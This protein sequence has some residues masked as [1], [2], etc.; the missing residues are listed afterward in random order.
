MTHRQPNIF[1][2]F[3]DL[4]AAESLRHGGVSPEPYQSL[5]LGL[6]T[7]D[8]P[9]NVEENRRRFFKDLGLEAAEVAG[10][11]QIHKD[12]VK[13]ISEPGQHEGFDALITDRPNV[14]LTITVADCVPILIYDAEKKAVGAA[15]AGWKGTVAEIGKKTLL[16]MQQQFGTRPA[17]CFVFIGTCIDYDSFEVDNDVAMYFDQPFKRWDDDKGKFFVDLKKVN[18][19]FM[20]KSG[21]PIHQISVSPFS[22]VKNNQDYF[23]HR[24]ERGKTGR[25]LGLIGLRK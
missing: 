3:S 22:T 18:R 13:V 8:T 25:G 24:K 21:V 19:Y 9:E 14:F 4:I 2:S 10:A 7:D 15:H 12:E 6:Y 5:N 20:E 1:E 16:A 23:S 17:S 11:F